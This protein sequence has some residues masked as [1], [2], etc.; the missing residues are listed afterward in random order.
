MFYPTFYPTTPS[1]SA[2]PTTT[3][4][5]PPLPQ[6]WAE[7]PGNRRCTFL[8]ELRDFHQWWWFGKTRGY[9]WRSAIFNWSTFG[10]ARVAHYGNFPFSPTQGCVRCIANRKSIKGLSPPPPWYFPSAAVIRRLLYPRKI[11]F[12]CSFMPE[13][14]GLSSG[15]ASCFFQR[16]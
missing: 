13:I 9:C 4:A 5:S 12:P 1:D 7:Y 16:K 14:L 15:A 3:P 2:T 6:I 10:L 11:P 8:V